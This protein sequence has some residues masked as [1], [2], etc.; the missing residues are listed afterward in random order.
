MWVKHISKC[1]HQ[2]SSLARQQWHEF[3]LQENI[4]TEKWRLWTICPVIIH[5]NATH[6]Q[7]AMCL[8]RCTE[9]QIGLDPKLTSLLCH[10]SPHA[11]YSRDIHR[12]TNGENYRYKSMRGLPPPTKVVVQCEASCYP[13]MFNK[14]TKILSYMVSARFSHTKSGRWDLEGPDQQLQANI[15]NSTTNVQA[16]Q[17]TSQTSSQEKT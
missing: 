3:W 16:N 11:L 6:K 2:V 17:W 9:G 5:F 1:R 7:H 13:N 14:G 12:T 10:V 15:S 4:L 8:W